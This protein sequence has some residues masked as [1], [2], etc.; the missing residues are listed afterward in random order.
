MSANVNATLAERDRERRFVR[1]ARAGWTRVDSRGRNGIEQGIAREW[2]AAQ[3][4]TRA[5][6]S[7]MGDR[8]AAED[9]RRAQYLSGGGESRL[10]KRAAASTVDLRNDPLRVRSIRKRGHYDVTGVQIGDRRW[11]NCSHTQRQVCRMLL[12]GTFGV[13][14]G[15]LVRVVPIRAVATRARRVL[16]AAPI[17]L[18]HTG[19]RDSLLRQRAAA[20]C[21]AGENRQRKNQADCGAKHAGIRFRGVSYL[22]RLSADW[23]DRST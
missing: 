15:R 7:T 21:L 4:G 13:M 14:R 8:S 19:G 22:C 16:V 6:V 10:T 3:C 5:P 1:S 20:K 17:V 18:H 2:K 9:V 12:A 11:H 23:R